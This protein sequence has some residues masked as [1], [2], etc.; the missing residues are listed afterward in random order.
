M[1]LLVEGVKGGEFFSVD[2][3]CSFFVPIGGK[4]SNEVVVLVM[5]EALRILKRIH[6]KTNY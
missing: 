6:W 2:P 1:Q 3:S 4:E 5:R